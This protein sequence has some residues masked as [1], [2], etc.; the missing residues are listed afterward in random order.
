MTELLTAMLTNLG[1]QQAAMLRDDIA[2]LQR[3]NGEQAYLATSLKAALESGIEPSE[4]QR[5]QMA[6][7]NELAET[8]RLLARQ[9]VNFA[10]R[11]LKALGQEQSYGEDGKPVGQQQGKARVDIR[12]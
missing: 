12:A 5:L 11:M 1:N 8:N 7:L 9:S 3:L 10:R 4:E 6:E 2:E